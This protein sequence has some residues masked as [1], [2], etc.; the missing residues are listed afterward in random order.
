M[1][2]N[3]KIISLL[4]F[5]FF[6]GCGKSQ[7]SDSLNS[8]INTTHLDFL[9]ED[10]KVDDREM[11]IIH[12]YS[13]YPEY[14]WIG[15]DDEGIACVDDAARAAVFYLKYHQASGNKETLRKAKNLLE[16][17]VYMQSDNGFFYNFIWEDYSI[18][19]DFKTS[20]AEPNWWSWRALWALCEGY[21]FFKDN[22]EFFSE[23]LFKTIEKAI[24]VIKKNIPSKHETKNVYGFIRPTWLP[25]E[26]ASD[27]A[28][29]LLLGLSSYLLNN[30]DEI[31]LNYCNKLT[32]GIILMQEGEQNYFPYGAFMSWEN[33]WHGWGNLQA[34]SLLKFYELTKDE[35]L[36]I[37]ALKEIDN[38]SVYLMDQAYYS[39]FKISKNE[40]KILPNQINQ[41]PQIAYILRPLVYSA[42]EAYKITKEEK[43][44]VQAGVI[45]NWF[46][47]K[48]PANEQMYFSENGKCF[49]GINN[50]NEINKNSGAES[51]IEALLALLEVEKNP[52]AKKELLV[53]N[54]INLEEEINK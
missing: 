9:Y 27:Q 30:K 51:T 14:E 42:L 47:G 36:K 34:Y 1:R 49:D 48:N 15:D 24:A 4:F 31:I 52:I 25:Y 50:E 2:F 43:Y 53:I 22:D 35:K 29:V 41:F 17:L 33:L 20:V 38:F 8:I 45:A 40:E 26:T 13:N 54:K 39:D 3:Y 21:N 5:V 10:I 28:A 19:K 6:V 23:K 12:I 18:N 16:F 44:G 32:D 37:A 7:T 46:F 11:G